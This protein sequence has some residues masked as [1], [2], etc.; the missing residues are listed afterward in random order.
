VHLESVQNLV[1]NFQ[2]LVMSLRVDKQVINVD[3]DVEI[4]LRM[5]SMRHWKLSGHLRRPMGDVIQWYWP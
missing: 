2:M 5:P 3:N 4:F 1:E